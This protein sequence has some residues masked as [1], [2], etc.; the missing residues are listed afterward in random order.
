MPT[1]FGLWKFNTNIP[2]PQSPED[3]IRQSEAFATLIKN[4]LQ[5]GQLKEVHAFLEGNRGYFVTGDVAYEQTYEALS[6]W[7][8][9]V[10]FELHRTIP[11]PRAIDLFVTATKKRAGRG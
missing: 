8:P 10:T 6:M 2:P 5:A 7:S 3:Q 4:Q 11:F 1:Y 9:Y